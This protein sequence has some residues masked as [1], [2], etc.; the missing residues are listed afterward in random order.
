[1]HL[2]HI[3]YRAGAVLTSVMMTTKFGL[4]HAGVAK[5]RSKNKAAIF[6][7][8][9]PSGNRR[10][11]FFRWRHSSKS[12][13]LIPTGRGFLPATNRLSSARTKAPGSGH[14]AGKSWA[15]LLEKI[16]LFVI[17]ASND[18]AWLR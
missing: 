17:L 6:R 7:M 18:R 9:Y 1:M 3:G 8:R 16:L 12:A 11:V 4:D 5:L 2:R 15:A 14:F 10:G 13:T